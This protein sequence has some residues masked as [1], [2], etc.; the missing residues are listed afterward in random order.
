MAQNSCAGG[1]GLAAGP[2]IIP[3]AME[4]HHKGTKTQRRSG[5]NSLV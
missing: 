5:W 1:C 2:E 3:S 4:T